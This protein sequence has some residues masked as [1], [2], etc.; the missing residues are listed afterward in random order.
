MKTMKQLI[1]DLTKTVWNTFLARPRNEHKEMH[2]SYQNLEDS[3]TEVVNRH[4]PD[5]GKVAPE[6][7]SRT[8]KKN[9]LIKFLTWWTGGAASAEYIQRRIDWYLYKKPLD[10][11]LNYPT[12]FPVKPEDRIVAGLSVRDWFLLK[13]QG[14][15]T[16]EGDEILKQYLVY[17]INAPAFDNPLTD[18]L[19]KEV[20]ITKDI[21]EL[22]SQCI[23]YGLD[24][25]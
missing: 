2:F 21:D 14:K 19:R 25:F 13:C 20:D 11:V 1:S 9:E 10:I 4:I 16:P 5:Q 7:Q 15:T 3:I 18:Q 22:I 6:K 12:G 8:D 24:P 17:F 23:G